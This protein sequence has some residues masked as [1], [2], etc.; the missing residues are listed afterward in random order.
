MLGLSLFTGMVFEMIDAY[1]GD[2]TS[3]DDRDLD[4]A[5]K[6]FDLDIQRAENDLFMAQ[7]RLKTLYQ[8]NGA[9]QARIIAERVRRAKAR[10]KS[11]TKTEAKAEEQPEAPL[12]ATIDMA[13]MSIITD[14]VWNEFSGEGNGLA[15]YVEHYRG[16]EGRDAKMDLIYSMSREWSIGH[17]LIFID[18]HVNEGTDQKDNTWCGISEHFTEECEDSPVGFKIVNMDYKIPVTGELIDVW[19]SLKARL[20]TQDPITEVA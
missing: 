10:F 14:I 6:Q 18:P 7:S 11:P 4:Y 17:P 12:R 9:L 16:T 3:L 19:D 2:L 20:W 15:G 1:E 13:R 8:A 5:T